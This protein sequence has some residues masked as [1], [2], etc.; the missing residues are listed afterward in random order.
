MAN[1]EEEVDKIFIPRDYK[2]FKW[3]FCR[4]MCENSNEPLDGYQLFMRSGLKGFMGSEPLMKDYV[5]DDA[6]NVYKVFIDRVMRCL[7][8]RGLVRQVRRTGEETVSY[9]G[10][11]LL[12]EKCPRFM[13][14]LMGD[15]DSI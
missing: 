13:D 6:E 3:V 2:L 12:R 7:V 11:D 15:I 9:E 10:T 14:Y 8:D 4:Y 1:I 5:L